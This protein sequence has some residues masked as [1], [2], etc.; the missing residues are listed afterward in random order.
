MNFA[1]LKFLFNYIKFPLHPYLKFIPQTN[2]C[3]IN[4]SKF[5]TSICFMDFMSKW[6][7]NILMRKKITFYCTHIYTIWP[8]SL[9]AILNLSVTG[10]WRLQKRIRHCQLSLPPNPSKGSM[11][12]CKTLLKRYYICSKLIIPLCCYTRT[13]MCRKSFDVL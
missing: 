3:V 9:Q 11:F 1:K 4:V 5:L 7:H 2:H 10:P 8:I 6:I 13:Y 12:P